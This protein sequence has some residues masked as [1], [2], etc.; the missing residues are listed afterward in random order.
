MS[1]KF[2]LF[3]YYS[4]IHQESILI[5][6]KGPVTPV[7]MA[8]ISSDIREKL[9]ENPTASRKVFSVFMELA[10]N[11]LYYSA[12]KV[13]F[14]DRRD[15]VGML[16]VTETDDDYIFSCGNL[17]K[18]EFVEELV[19]SCDTINSLSRDELRKYKREQRNRPQKERS[20][21]AGIG[22]IHV[23]ITSDSPL[24]LEVHNVN[25]EV[26]FFSLSVKITK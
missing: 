22:L 17:V 6:Y 3:E 18:S 21:G 13:S 2:S 12:E 1:R 26:S 9:A 11:I 19:E 20:K 10:Q 7:I 25:D 4:L 23:A 5:S 15:S 14:S 24:E 16:L 8:E